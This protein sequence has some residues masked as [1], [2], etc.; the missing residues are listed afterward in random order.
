MKT[1]QK[2]ILPVEEKLL[3][4]NGLAAR[5]EMHPITLRR[6]EKAGKLPFLKLG[7]RG[8]R[9]R[10]SDIERIEAEAEVSL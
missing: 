4:R 1:L 2:N 3:S 9:Y 6:K 7:A 5:W 8:V 10:L